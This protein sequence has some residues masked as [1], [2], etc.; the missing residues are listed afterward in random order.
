VIVHASRDG[1][2]ASVAVG[3]ADAS[4]RPLAAET[5]MRV[6]SL[7]K[8]FV[9]TLVLQLVQE[10]DLDLDTP[11]GQVMPEPR[12]GADATIRQLLEHRSGVPDYTQQP[13][14]FA[15]VLAE[16]DRDLSTD[17]ILAY[18]EA[19]TTTAAGGSFAYSNTN[20][21]L[22]G[23]L[24]EHLEGTDLQTVLRRRITEPLGLQSTS[25]AMNGDAPAD[26]AAGWSPGTL[27]GDPEAPYDSI[28][29]SAWAAGGLVSTA[30]ELATFLTELF[31]GRLL[32]GPSLEAMTATDDD[33]YGLGLLA[34][35]L[36]G[37]GVGYAHSGA[38]PGFSSTAGID[39]DGEHLLVVLTNN[40][41]LLADRLAQEIVTA[42]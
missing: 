22:L 32:D 8:P 18:A 30:P 39:P 5:P 7:S 11:L 41:A 3:D 6:G 31:D 21:V 26:L 25:F 42:W 4:G 12:L 16:G 20:Y 36:G 37:A 2:Q 14:F 40:D 33:G 29:S 17:E 24:V 38:I 10:H 28:A 34:A 1:L 27:A 23:L 15:D 9:A 19:G 35:G 13:A